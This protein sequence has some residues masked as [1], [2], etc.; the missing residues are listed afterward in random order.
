MEI[1]KEKIILL[2]DVLVFHLFGQSIIGQSPRRRGAQDS[3]CVCKDCLLC[4]HEESIPGRRKAGK[5]VKRPA[6]MTTKL[7]D[8]LAHNK[9]LQKEWKKGQLEWRTY[10]EVL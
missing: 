3:W 1:S 5:N 7:L 9:K 10:K 4:V 2:L 6:W 8:T